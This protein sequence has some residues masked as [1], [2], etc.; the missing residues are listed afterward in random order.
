VRDHDFRA[1]PR[2]A[3]LDNAF[4]D[5]RSLWR[6]FVL[7]VL[8]RRP[9]DSL[10]IIV[11]VI[12]TGA[13]M[14]NALMLQTGP[15]PAPLFLTAKPVA[16]G[17]STSAAVTVLPGPRPAETGTVKKHAGARSR[18]EIVA[19]IQKELARRGFYEGSAD[20][21]YGP[22]TDAAIRDFEQ[23]AGLK[24][25]GEP[26]ETLLR[27]IAQSS[28]RARAP[29]ESRP[30]DPIAELL[31]PSKQVKAVQRVL[32]AFGYGQINPSGVL[33]PETQSAIQ[34]FE[35]ERKLPITGQV[36]DRLRR[37]LMVLSGRPLE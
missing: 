10:A 25:S 5:T 23:V 35:R 7:T 1:R 12:S 31:A 30:N 8:S 17:P 24:P 18:T 15:H 33:D 27:A 16:A 28:V 14:V 4:P 22:K 21:V 2:A 3:A 11:A 13:I 19:E 29:T 26:N 32:A 36:S 20:G 37:E 9:A 34:S 6:G